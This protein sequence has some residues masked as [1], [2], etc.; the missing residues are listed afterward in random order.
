[1]G[2]LALQANDWI[3]ELS[4][5]VAELKVAVTEDDTPLVEDIDIEDGQLIL[6]GALSTTVNGKEQLFVFPALSVA[7]H[8]TVVVVEMRKRATP[9]AGQTREAIPLPSL[10]VTFH[11]KFTK[12]SGRLSDGIVA[13]EKLM[14]QF[15]VGFVESAAV[16][17]N[18]HVFV[19]PT[20]SV[21]EQVT[22][23][24]PRANTAGVK[25]EAAGEHDTAAMPLPSVAATVGA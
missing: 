13:Y 25:V 3:P 20:L 19:L 17:E 14:G 12:G 11:A 8:A 5:A 4:D 2:L 18:L 22:V 23:V 16:T 9:E 21:A 10:A 7:V 6:G 24:T 1:M 15:M